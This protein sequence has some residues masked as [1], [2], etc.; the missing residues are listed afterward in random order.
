ML[1]CLPSSSARALSWARSSLRNVPYW[2]II[3]PALMRRRGWYFA[4]LF[5][6]NYYI[7]MRNHHQDAFGKT[8]ISQIHEGIVF[9][10]WD[11]QCNWYIVIGLELEDLFHIRHRYQPSGHADIVQNYEV[12]PMGEPCNDRQSNI[13]GIFCNNAF[14]ITAYTLR[15]ML[16]RII[17]QA[18]AW[19]CFGWIYRS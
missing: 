16:C 12:R 4:L 18:D 5:P 15:I 13:F 17:I 8:H 10:V 11:R 2:R 19:F 14:W 3:G 1:N 7:S 6:G 9:V